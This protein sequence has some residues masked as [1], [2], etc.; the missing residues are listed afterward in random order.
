[1][2]YFVGV[3]V[4]IL[5]IGGLFVGYKLGNSD[6]TTSSPSTSTT[7]TDT[8]TNSKVL[9]LSNTGLTEVTSNVYS[10]TS[11]TDLILS[12]NSIKSLPSEMG[13]M[14]NVL[15][16]KIDHN[17]LEGSLIG[18]IRQMSKL[19]QLDVSYNNMTGMPAEIGQLSKLEILNY[20]YNNIS[21]LPNELSNLKNNLKEF[22][23]TGNPLSQEQI[24]NLK[25]SLPN[26]TI[27]F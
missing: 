15:I 22:N 13:K 8:G 4:T 16:F 12:N 10:K 19:K 14:T 1:M 24:N 7:N 25:T 21:G 18:E 3:L 17:I 11:T 23:L 26:T 5:I 9:D 27:I 2:K 20:S 6:D